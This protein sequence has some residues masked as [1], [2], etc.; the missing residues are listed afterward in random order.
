VTD[1]ASHSPALSGRRR[2]AARND[3]RILKAARD[4]FVAD[5]SAPI[6]DVAKRAGVGIRLFTRDMRGRKIFSASFVV[7]G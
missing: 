2:Q 3:Q 7:M 6:S 4:V 1:T 5:P